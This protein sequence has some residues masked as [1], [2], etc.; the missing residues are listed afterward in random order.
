MNSITRAIAYIV[1]K[2]KFFFDNLPRLNMGLTISMIIVASTKDKLAYS[3]SFVVLSIMLLLVISTAVIGAVMTKVN[4]KEWKKYR[5][6]SWRIMFTA[7]MVTILIMGWNFLT[8]QPLES[9]V[10]FMVAAVLFILS[11]TYFNTK[12]TLKINKYES[13]I[14]NLLEDSRALQIVNAYMNGDNFKFVTK[15]L[16]AQIINERKEFALVVISFLIPKLAILEDELDF[17]LST[18]DSPE[19]SLVINFFD[20]ELVFYAKDYEA[21]Y[22]DT[23]LTLCFSDNWPTLKEIVISVENENLRG[24]H[25]RIFYRQDFGSNTREIPIIVPEHPFTSERE[26]V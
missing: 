7:Y 15:D 8:Y 2:E 6:W 18:P 23:L 21:I 11:F 25:Y 19:D 17:D 9:Y 1:P 4:N 13:E 14:K 5:N 20:N 3:L 12:V 26:Y 24:V 16:S 22:L 10:Q